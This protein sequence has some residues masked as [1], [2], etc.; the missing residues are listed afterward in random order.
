MFL[1]ENK[2]ELLAKNMIF[3]VY[4]QRTNTHREMIIHRFMHVNFSRSISCFN[5]QIKVNLP[6]DTDEG[7]EEKAMHTDTEETR[8]RELQR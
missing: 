1:L 7:S 8:G 3:G 6:L 2:T 4:M 5:M